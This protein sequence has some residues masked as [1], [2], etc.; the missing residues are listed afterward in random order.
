[1]T[2]FDNNIIPLKHKLENLRYILLINY[3]Q[4]SSL[5]TFIKYMQMVYHSLFDLVTQ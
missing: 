3:N 1:M 2:N 5:I 4:Q